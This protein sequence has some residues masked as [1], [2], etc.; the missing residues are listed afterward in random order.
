MGP[1]TPF[2]TAHSLPCASAHRHITAKRGT[3]SDAVSVRLRTGGRFSRSR[4]PAPCQLQEEIVMNDSSIPARRQD[5]YE[6]RFTDGQ[7]AVLDLS[8]ARCSGHSSRSPRGSPR[9]RRS[10]PSTSH[11]VRARCGS[12]TSAPDRA[13]SAIHFAVPLMA[14]LYVRQRTELCLACAY[15]VQVARSDLAGRAGLVSDASASFRGELNRLT[16]NLRRSS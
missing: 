10:T 1:T 11:D 12:A 4:R 13:S 16:R 9:L 5:S 3:S 6:L 7:V 14:Q 15:P 2:G 8:D